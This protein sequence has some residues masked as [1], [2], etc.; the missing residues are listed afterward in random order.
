LTYSNNSTLNTPNGIVSISP[1]RPRHQNHPYLHFANIP[2]R[3]QTTRRLHPASLRSRRRRNRRR[4]ASAHSNRGQQRTLGH[5]D[6]RD[7]ASSRRLAQNPRSRMPLTFS[8]SRGSRNWKARPSLLQARC[9]E[10]G[11]G[12]RTSGFG[13]GGCSGGNTGGGGRWFYGL[14]GRRMACRS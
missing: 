4:A 6:L 10:N 1:V 14:G 2:S 7:K 3:H 9:Q 13:V 12:D 11:I 8:Y 5:R